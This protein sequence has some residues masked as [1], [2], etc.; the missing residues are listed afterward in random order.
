MASR[1]AAS[2]PA[3]SPQGLVAADRG[4]R[5]PRP[6]GMHPDHQE[7]LRKNRVVLAKQLLLSELLEHLLEKDVVTLEM[8]EL[9]QA[10]AGSFSQNVELLNLLPK[11]GPQAFEAFLGALRETKQSHLEELLLATLADLPRL[12]P[13]VPSPRNLSCDYDQNFPFPVCESCSPHKQLRLSPDAVEHSLDDGDGPPSLRVRPCTP[14]FYQTH[15]QLAYRLQSR[16]RGLALVLSNVHFTGEKDLEFRSGGDVDHSTLVALFKLLGYSVHVL[17]DQTAQ[18]MQEKLQDF[19]QL[20]AHRVTDSCIVALLS[21][22]V[23]GGVY[24]V[25]GKLLQLHEVFRL[26]DNAN[27]PSLQNKPKMFFVQACRGDET[28]RGVDQQDGRSRA[29]APGCEDGEAGKEGMLKVRLPTRSDMI[30]GYAC[31]RGTAAMRN[32]KR[33][34]WYVEAL[35]QVFSERACDM[36]VADMLVQ[37]NALIKEREGYAPGTEFHRCKEMSEYCSTLCRHLYL[38]PGHP[39]T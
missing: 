14:E 18:E 28:D 17:L 10:K 37:V 1:R 38:F 8:R 32:T 2:R 21:H 39:P 11:R 3:L 12:L 9:I 31:L 27:C 36:H 5:T 4:R 29:A 20:P 30:C 23:E 22:G 35:Q 7:A 24:G 26:F 34:S 16:P 15:C 13:P 33:G 6:C 25:D 19:A